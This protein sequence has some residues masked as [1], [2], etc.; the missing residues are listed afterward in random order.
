ML[1]QLTVAAL[2]AMGFWLVLRSVARPSSWFELGASVAVGS[3]IYV[4]VM[5]VFCMQPQDRSDMRLALA[6]ARSRIPGLGR[7]RA[8]IGSDGGEA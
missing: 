8:E 7:R 6:A 4:A 3:A 1:I 5:L 2:V